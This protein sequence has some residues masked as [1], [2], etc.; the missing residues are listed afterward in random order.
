M[1]LW[2]HLWE[3]WSEDLNKTRDNDEA[4][5]KITESVSI[6]NWKMKSKLIKIDLSWKNEKEVKKILDNLL[7]L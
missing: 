4:K 6:N 7:N 5:T 1:W 2:V 3:L